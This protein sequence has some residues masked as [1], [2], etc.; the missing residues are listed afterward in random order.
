MPATKT[1]AE[2]ANERSRYLGLA[3]PYIAAG[4]PIPS[5]IRDG[6]RFVT[7]QERR[8]MLENPRCA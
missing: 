8:W 5:D 3:A 4:R 6:L 2:I 7:T 1:A